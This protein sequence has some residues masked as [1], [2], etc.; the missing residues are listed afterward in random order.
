[1]P[2]NLGA[3]QM[4]TSFGNFSFA[5]PPPNKDVACRKYTRNIYQ[6]KYFF[7]KNNHAV[8]QSEKNLM[9]IKK[10]LKTY[11]WNATEVEIFHPIIA[12]YCL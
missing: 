5:S 12:P 6:L 1:M 9:L 8:Y 4:G 11:L 10:N 2:K 3:R 7:F